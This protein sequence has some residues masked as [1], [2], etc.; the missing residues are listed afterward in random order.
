MTP[1]TKDTWLSILRTVFTF[2]GTYFVGR[3]I[4]GHTIDSNTLEIVGGSI[5]ALGSIIWGIV[6]KSAGIEQI[7]SA[8]RSI[9]ISL[10]GVAVSF[11]LIKNEVVITLLALLTPIITLIQ[12]WTSKAKVEKIA[13]SELKPEIKGGDIT[14]KV[15]KMI[16]ILILIG[17]CNSA[18]AQSFFKPLPK[19]TTATGKFVPRAEVTTPGTMMNSF[20]PLVGITASI[21]DGT[22]LAGG[23]G[24]GFQHNIFDGPSNSWVTQYSVSGLVFIDTKASIIGGLAFGFLNF[25]NLGPGYDFTT[26]KFV[27]LTG[28]QIK[29]N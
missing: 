8:L 23:I 26:K 22:A 28:V 7:E 11:G 17:V 29:F 12:S 21:S 24:G 19:P 6:D 10:G 2:A 3:N 18:S 16:A 4:F 1:S 14:G 9:L 15:T 27:L 13:K 5:L 25:I 20:R